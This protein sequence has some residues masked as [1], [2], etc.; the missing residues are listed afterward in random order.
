MNGGHKGG[1][2]GGSKSGVEK[3]R[4]MLLLDDDKIEVLVAFEPYFLKYLHDHL[5][6][7]NV[8]NLRKIM[9]QIQTDMCYA[10]YREEKLI[11]AMLNPRLNKG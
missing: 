4:K 6:S 2:R 3:Q 7:N 1:F 5:N 8:S 10:K 11:I 9:L